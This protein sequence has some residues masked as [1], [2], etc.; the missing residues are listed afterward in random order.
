MFW[1]YGC[2]MIT[3]Q[4]ILGIDSNAK[5]KKGLVLNYTTAI[6]YL[7]P[8]TKSG[9]N[10]C[11]FSSAGCEGACLDTAGRGAM[12]PIQDARLKKTFFFLNEQETFIL[13]L[14]QEIKAFERSAGKKNLIPCARLNG[15]SDVPWHNIGGIMQEF[16]HIQF[17]DYTPNPHRMIQFLR[18]ELP[19][20]YHLTFSRKENND[21]HCDLI[22]SMGGNVAVVFDNLP[23]TWK[24]YPVVNGDES[25][26]RFLD[27]K[28]VIVGLKAKGKG[29]KD[30]SG[31][32][33]KI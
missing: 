32:V 18:G 11:A 7:S 26:L 23:S 17:Y 33:I 9:K 2:P 6:V 29:K 16:S 24:G 4:K 25:D 19:S 30:A 10:L 21:A 12:K 3:T 28:N 27:P 8:S 20:N 14:K 5:T 31:F 1:Q 22:L 15:T 13:Q